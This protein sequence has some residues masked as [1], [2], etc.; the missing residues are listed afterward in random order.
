RE[1]LEPVPFGEAQLAVAHECADGTRARH[2]A[3]PAQTRAETLT[4]AAATTRHGQSLAIARVIRVT[5]A[6]GGVPIEKATGHS[7]ENGAGAALGGPGAAPDLYFARL[8]LAA[9][10]LRELAGSARG[11]PRLAVFVRVGLLEKS[12]SR[13]C[14]GRGRSPFGL[15]AASP[16]LGATTT[17]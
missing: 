17:I 10:S 7:S 11:G 14:C 3:V 16:R 13:T 1:Q 6:P 2:E 12:R 15:A 4:A 8:R 9:R 5:Q